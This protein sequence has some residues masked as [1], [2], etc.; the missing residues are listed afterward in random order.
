MM[1][2]IWYIFLIIPIGIFYIFLSYLFSID[3]KNSYQKVN[4]KFPYFSETQ[5]SQL[6]I[7]NIKIND[8]I[9]RLRILNP[10]ASGDTIILL[11]G[12]PQTSISWEPV[13]D[14]FE[15]SDYRIIAYDQRGYSPLARPKS[16]SEYT[17]K[18]LIDDLLGVADALGAEK[19]H[20]IGHDWGAAIGWS[21]VMSTPER[22]LSWT[23]LSIPH[24][25][26]FFN[27]V[28]T[29]KT[30]RKKSR[31]ILFLQIPW[32]PEFLLVAHR[33]FFL[34]KWIIKVMPK[35]HQKEYLNLYSEFGAMNSVLKYYRA[36]GKSEKFDYQAEIGVP[37]L[38]I[39][40]NNDPAVSRYAVE[41]Q[42]KYIQ[43]HFEEIELDAGH[44]LLETRAEKIIKPIK[45]HIEKSSS[46]L[47]P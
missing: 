33:S 6:V 21:T 24:P 25:L 26:A 47:N 42:K 38:F 44:W 12:F 15:N 30:Q 2:S 16:T 14:S 36:I 22:I 41:T 37:T 28:R 20:L 1:L 4:S 27:A 19:F 3:W 5:S 45:D 29:N 23:A 11:H 10:N 7:A 17:T 8:L 13:F 35:H 39:W 18:F 32:I 43:G 34:K 46:L 40:G 9:F 31:Y